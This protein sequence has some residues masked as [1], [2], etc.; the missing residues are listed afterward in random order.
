MHS[1]FVKVFV[2]LFFLAVVLWR[3]RISRDVSALVLIL[4]PTYSWCIIWELISVWES[5]IWYL[6]LNGTWKLTHS[7]RIL[8]FPQCI[9]NF[10]VPLKGKGFT[11]GAGEVFPQVHLS[12]EQLVSLDPLH[13]E[14]RKGITTGNRCWE[15]PQRSL[16][17]LFT[18]ESPGRLN[19]PVKLLSCKAD[20][21]TRDV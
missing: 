3:A 21:L 9:S 2:P 16:F 20:L 1:A 10:D 15:S 12:L 19:F 8:I 11:K 6:Y 14:W 4:V 17:S 7:K 18:V 13:R 5:P